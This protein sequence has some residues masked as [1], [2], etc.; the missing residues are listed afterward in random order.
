MMDDAPSEEVGSSIESSHLSAKSCSNRAVHLIPAVFVCAHARGCMHVCARVYRKVCV[1]V[2]V[3]NYVCVRMLNNRFGRFRIMACRS[4]WGFAN[5][6]SLKSEKGDGRRHRE[7][8]SW[9]IEGA[10]QLLG[11][12]WWDRGSYIGR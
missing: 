3:Q 7:V 2:C 10:S 1:C 4:A 8:E 11:E 6:R 9:S 5:D 12:N